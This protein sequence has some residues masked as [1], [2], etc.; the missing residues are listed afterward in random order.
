MINVQGDN[1]DQGLPALAAKPVVVEL[2]VEDVDFSVR[3]S[4]N[5]RTREEIDFFLN[6]DAKMLISTREK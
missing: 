5:F 6:C 4:W 3:H 1:T 2:D